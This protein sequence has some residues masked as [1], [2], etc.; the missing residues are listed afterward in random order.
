MTGGAPALDFETAVVA[1]AADTEHVYA[2]PASLDELL[3]VVRRADGAL[4]E[5]IDGNTASQPLVH[6]VLERALDKADLAGWARE[7][8]RHGAQGGVES[9]RRRIALDTHFTLRADADFGRHQQEM[10]RA[11]RERLRS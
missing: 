8:G 7:L 5:E 11:I 10:D 2:D 9:L 1:C 4:L 6:R 3:G